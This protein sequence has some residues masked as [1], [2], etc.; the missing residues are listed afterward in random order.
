MGHHFF[1]ARVSLSPFSVPLSPQQAHAR[2]FGLLPQ[3][4]VRVLGLIHQI[5][6]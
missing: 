5:L 6:S 1:R 4:H 3:A 2:V